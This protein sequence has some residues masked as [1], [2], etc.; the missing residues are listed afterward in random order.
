M[1]KTIE[2]E[3]EAVAVVEGGEP[4]GP[5]GAWDRTAHALVSGPPEAI[6]VAKDLQGLLAPA[7]LDPA[8]I[9]GEMKR[10]AD[11]LRS[12]PMQERTR[13]WE[14]DVLDG[15]DRIGA[16]ARELAE[17]MALGTV[18]DL[19]AVREAEVLSNAAF[20]I[21][22]QFQ[23]LLAAQDEPWASRAKPEAPAARAREL[24]EIEAFLARKRRR[25]ARRKAG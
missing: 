23:G 7:I 14:L 5:D 25:E 18:T 16:D 1:S 17:R 12:R 6:E 9:A 8:R 22:T 21:R 11:Y 3:T 2:V 19:A 4:A 13:K 15:L 10:R 20:G 24:A